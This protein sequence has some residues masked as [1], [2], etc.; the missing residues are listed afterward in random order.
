MK[1]NLYNKN[2]LNH[3]YQIVI[4]L[5]FS[6]ISI[7]FIKNHSLISHDEAIYASRARLILENNKWFIPFESVHHKT[8][9][10]Y[11]LTAL[12]IKLFGSNEMAARLPS[13]L[14]SII[15][16]FFLV[17]ICRKLTTIKNS[18]L[19]FI[20]VNSTPLWFLYSHYCSPDMLFVLINIIPIYCFLKIKNINKKESYLNKFL[21]F[22]IGFCFSLGFFIRSFMQALP[23]ISYS[24]YILVFLLN[25]KKKEKYF[26][27][28]GILL[29]LLPSLIYVTLSYKEFGFD[30]IKYLFEFVLEKTIYD[31]G[32]IGLFFYPRN[33]ILF[34]MPSIIFTF[35][36]ILSVYKNY[37]LEEKILLLL[38]PLIF[39]FILMLTTSNHTHY[40]LFLAPWFSILS[41]IGIDSLYQNQK[42]NLLLFRVYA[43]FIFILGIFLLFLNFLNFSKL[44]IDK[45]LNTLFFIIIT[46]ISILFLYLSKVMFTSI[47]NKKVFI[48]FIY[49]SLT[50]ISI[51]LSTLFLFGV[52]NNPNLQFKKFISDNNV[53]NILEA[54][55]IYL[56]D[57]KKDKKLNSLLK[58]Y[59]P[60][61]DDSLEDIKRYNIKKKIDSNLDK[62]YIFVD[63]NLIIDRTFIEIKSFYN[64][65]LIKLG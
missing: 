3:K 55:K 9:G 15:S 48:K 64:Y 26:I 10:S 29:G 59:I 61:Y 5:F 30:S 43:I 14:I 53:K 51:T 22:L 50:S 4:I 37:K 38:T 52:L 23:L 60:R 8:I 57:T 49:L 24:P 13:V 2:F 39:L 58:F 32:K 28:Y 7:F 56:V 25:Y 63:K 40:I 18:Y 19:L 27:I 34:N 21:F 36:G 45:D 54:N 12:S 35:K 33:I 44:S 46:F 20:L 41:F 31:E 42:I 17:L 11:W 47:F 65:S 6:F 16:S 62:I 1:L